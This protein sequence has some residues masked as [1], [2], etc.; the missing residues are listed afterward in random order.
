MRQWVLSIYWRQIQPWSILCCT[1]MVSRLFSAYNREEAFVQNLFLYLNYC[2][3]Y[4]STTPAAKNLRLLWRHNQQST[5]F[6]AL[7]WSFW[8]RHSQ[9]STCFFARISRTVNLV[10]DVTREHVHFRADCTEVNASQ[11]SASSRYRIRYCRHILDS[12]LHHSRMR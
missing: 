5:S 12:L 9:Q 7:S 11:S 10:D 6:H 1:L 2:D 4:C 3:S 8:W